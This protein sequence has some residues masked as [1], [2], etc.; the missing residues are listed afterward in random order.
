MSSSEFEASSVISFF[1]GASVFSVVSAG[2]SSSAGAEVSSLFSSDKSSLFSLFSSTKLSSS[3]VV[4]GSADS[5]AT[6]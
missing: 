3:L 6:A 5:S 4:S 1:V 2:F